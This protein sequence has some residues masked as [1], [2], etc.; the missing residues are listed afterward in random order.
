MGYGMR[1]RG[2]GTNNQRLELIKPMIVPHNHLM[3]HAIT[4]LVFD[5]NHVMV[6]L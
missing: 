4:H 1:Y 6:P 5:A 3:V 2:G